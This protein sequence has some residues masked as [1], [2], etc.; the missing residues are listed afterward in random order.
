[1]V[2]TNMVMDANAA[3][4][5][6]MSVIAGSFSTYVHNMFSLRSQSQAPLIKILRSVWKHGKSRGGLT[7][8]CGGAFVEMDGRDA[9]VAGAP[10]LDRFSELEDPALVQ[11]DAAVH[12]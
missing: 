4:S 12:S 5:R 7:C 3:I 1:M 9:H 8:D 6:R 2:A 10:G 11:R